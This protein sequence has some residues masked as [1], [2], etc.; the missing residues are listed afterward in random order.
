MNI[1]D[2]GYKTYTIDSSRFVYGFSSLID[3]DP[4]SSAIEDSIGEHYRIF[5]A[6]DGAYLLEYRVRGQRA[7]GAPGFS[8]A[9]GFFPIPSDVASLL[10]GRD[11]SPAGEGAGAVPDTKRS[12]DAIIADLQI[13]LSQ[14]DAVIAESVELKDDLRN[15]LREMVTCLNVNSFRGCLAM[16]GI[17]LERILKHF[18]ARHSI[19]FAKD[20]M[21]GRLLGDIEKSGQYVDPTVKNIWNII[22][23]QRII[24]VHAKEGVPI[25][26]RDQT[27]MVV[28][29]VKDTV[30]RI[31]TA[32]QGAAADADKPRR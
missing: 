19:P 27:F 6:E 24:G 2:V 7:F 22:N 29:A 31:L 17:V 3:Y 11:R 10:I 8:A 21:V 14:M 9:E 28:F 32:E 4:A 26:S 5:Q 15:D 1:L 12:F 20:S 30:T 18:L 16:A 13:W 25:P 23:A